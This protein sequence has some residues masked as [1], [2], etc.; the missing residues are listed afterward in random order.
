MAWN[1]SNDKPIF[2][3]LVDIITVDI[4]NGKY[5][6]GEKLLPVR[7]L[8]VMAGVNPNT[9]QRALAAVEESGLIYTKRG[10]G[11]YVSEDEGIVKSALQEYVV[12]IVRDFISAMKGL[13][14]DENQ[15]LTF[16]KSS[17]NQE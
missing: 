6:P 10:D 11:R 9:M 1:F 2:Q 5:S 16:V 13:G 8:A 12:K 4:I 17:L 14:L 15:I 7:E 3:Q